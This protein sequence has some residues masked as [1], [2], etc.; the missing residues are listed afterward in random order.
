M[1]APV[2]GKPVLELRAELGLPP[3][4]TREAIFGAQ[5]AARWT[6]FVFAQSGGCWP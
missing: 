4:S 6:V 2:R 5:D 3:M 1:G